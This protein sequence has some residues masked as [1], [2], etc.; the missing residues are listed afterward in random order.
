MRLL[1]DALSEGAYM[2]GKDRKVLYWNTEA[3]RI[4]GFGR[5]EVVG[6]HCSDSILN[7]VDGHGKELCRGFCPLAATLEDSVNRGGLIY[8]HHRQGH[9]VAVEARTLALILENGEPVG[10]ELFHEAGSRRSLVDQVNRLR[11]LSLADPLTGLP[12]RRQLE[13]V[14]EARLAS[15]RRTGISFGIMFIDIDRFKECNDRYGH[16][17]GDRVL[18]TVGRTLFSSVRPLDTVGRWGGEEF[19]GVFPRVSENGL[20]EIGERLR[21]LVSVT[22]TAFEGASITVTVSIGATEA[23]EN[24]GLESLVKR[25]DAL[26]Y[27]GKKTGRNRVVAG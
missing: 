3:E 2:V 22:T 11:E 1:L 6:K 26:M 13:S 8:L 5:D 21:S 23:L 18:T 27:Q 14:M 15:M 17:A 9:R 12:N 4:T 19:L 10:V 7:H 20:L 25:A 24:D 16:A